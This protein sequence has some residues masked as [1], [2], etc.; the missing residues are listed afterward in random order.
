MSLTTLKPKVQTIDTRKGA[1]VATERIRG[2]ELQRIRERILLRDDYTCQ[3]C[4][5]VS[6]HLEIDHVKPLHLGGA[7][8]DSNRQSICRW[9]HEQKSA[10][11]AKGRPGGG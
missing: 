6:V 3:V 11:E 4:G 5:R 2:A 7:E 8:A 1:S 10:R 9:C